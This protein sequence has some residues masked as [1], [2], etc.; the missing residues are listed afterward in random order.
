MINDLVKKSTRQIYKPR[1]ALINYGMNRYSEELKHYML[2]ELEDLLI[3]FGYPNGVVSERTD[4]I[5]EIN[6]IFVFIKI[7]E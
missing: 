4:F 1:K 7:N 2:N 3:K 6:K 5:N